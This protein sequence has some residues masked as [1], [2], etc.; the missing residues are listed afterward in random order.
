MIP[1]T[2]PD[3]NSI[4]KPTLKFIS[5]ELVLNFWTCQNEIIP[6]ITTVLRT[7]ISQILH[8]MRKLKYEKK[9]NLWIHTNFWG[10]MQNTVASLF[11]NEM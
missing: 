6:D 5:L 2:E 11:L 1:E 10:V 3:T 7:I 9:S 4:I 8:D